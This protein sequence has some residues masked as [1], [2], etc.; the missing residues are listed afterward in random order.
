[1]YPHKPAYHIC[2]LITEKHDFY[3]CV[4]SV[5]YSSVVAFL[6]KW[7]WRVNC[8]IYLCNGLTQIWGVLCSYFN[9]QQK[10]TELD[11]YTT[12]LHQP[13]VDGKVSWKKVQ[14]NKEPCH[15]IF[16]KATNSRT[17]DMSCLTNNTGNSL[18][19]EWP[20]FW[21]SWQG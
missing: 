1:M 12:N 21:I 19:S 11:T 6:I 14:Y 13:A 2:V 20:I 8:A 9:T 18:S 7:F 10:F 4:Y 17:K 5:H 3:T 16:K 15:V